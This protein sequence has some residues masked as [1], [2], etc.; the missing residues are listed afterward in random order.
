VARP[1]PPRAPVSRICRTSGG[2]AGLAGRGVAGVVMGSALRDGEEQT[3]DRC[4]LIQLQAERPLGR[5]AR[6]PAAGGDRAAGTLHAQFLSWR[7]CRVVRPR[8]GWSRRAGMPAWAA[9]F[10]LT[11]SRLLVSAV[12]HSPAPAW[13]SIGL[14]RPYARV[15]AAASGSSLVPIPEPGP[16][17]APGAH[18]DPGFRGGAARVGQGRLV[19]LGQMAYS[20]PQIRPV[21]L[22]AVWRRVRRTA[23]DEPAGG[24]QEGD[25]S[26]QPDNARRSEAGLTGGRRRSAKRPA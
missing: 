22:P 14:G 10:T 26:A 20:S 15:P 11:W 3:G 4:G 19:R 1:I 16:P 13:S 7:C 18:R 25:H 6:Q 21:L 8:S 24:W 23:N 5:Q 17:S 9:T 12:R 2:G